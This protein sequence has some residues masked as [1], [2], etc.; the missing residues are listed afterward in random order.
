M[1]AYF[2][3]AYLRSART[4]TSVT[5]IP[6]PAAFAFTACH[7]A[8][9]TRTFRIGVCVGRTSEAHHIKGKT[10]GVR[11]SHELGGKRHGDGESIRGVR[12]VVVALDRHSPAREAALPSG[13]VDAWREGPITNRGRWVLRVCA[14]RYLD[15]T[16]ELDSPA[17]RVVVGP[18]A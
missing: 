11:A 2:R 16:F 18:G 7:R 6:S 9:G 10:L 8:S 1:T 12:P 13:S 3:A 4:M 17:G 14:D 15:A 5:V